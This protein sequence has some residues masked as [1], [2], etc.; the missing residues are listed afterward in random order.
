MHCPAAPLP[1]PPQVTHG[2]PAPDAFLAAAE[3]LGAAPADCL[4]FEDA[5][6]GVEAA[7][8]AGMRVVVV[9]SL[10][11]TS[12]YPPA[13]ASCRWAPGRQAWLRAPASPPCMFIRRLL[14]VVL[15]TPHTD[16]PPPPLTPSSLPPSLAPPPTGRLVWCR[17]SPRCSPSSPTAW[18]WPPS[19]TPWRASSLWWTRPSTSRG[20]WSR[21]LGA[22]PRCGRG[23]CGVLV[24]AGRGSAPPLGDLPLVPPPQ[25]LLTTFCRPFP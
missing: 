19:P 10:V 1:L 22:G 9:P 13:D 25:H 15:V 6:S 5:P 18:A 16:I 4:V 23:G 7:V 14:K 3:K 20:R 17:S 11:D 12:D 2:K 8:A 24:V 21:G